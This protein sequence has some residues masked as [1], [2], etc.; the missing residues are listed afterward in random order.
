M[1]GVSND[2]GSSPIFI[3]H[4][5]GGVIFC[6]G[7]WLKGRHFFRCFFGYWFRSRYFN[8]TDFS[9]KSIRSPNRLLDHLLRCF[10]HNRFC[11]GTSLVITIT[12]QIFG[13]SPYGGEFSWC[14]GFRIHYNK[15]LT[16]QPLCGRPLWLYCDFSRP[17]LLAN[18]GSA[19]LI[20]S[21]ILPSS[22][23]LT[24]TAT[25]SP[26]VS[27]PSTCSIRNGAIS[28]M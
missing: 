9:S 14:F 27:T 22:I 10:Y 12:I 13:V 17:R 25:V 5:D 28:E 3:V 6:W 24:I 2:G 4:D 15:Y 19:C 21:P 23:L 7:N 26:T 16:L 1:F 20:D 11:G 18:S 8:P